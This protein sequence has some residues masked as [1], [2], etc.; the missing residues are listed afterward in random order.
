MKDA[1]IS[2]LIKKAKENLNA[3]KN[4]LAGNISFRYLQEKLETFF[5]L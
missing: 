4:L 3:A 5:N 1:D 2:D